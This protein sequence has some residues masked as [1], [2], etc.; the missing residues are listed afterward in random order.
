LLKLAEAHD[1]TI[2]EDDIFADFEIEPTTR[3]AAL[4]GLNRVIHIGSFSKTLSA[5]LRCGFIS[6]NASVIEPLLD[7]NLAIHLGGGPGSADIVHRVLTNGFY[8]RHTSALRTRLG[9]GMG[10]TI[11]KIHRAGLT[12]WIE[13]RGGIFLW[14]RLPD[15]LKA[16]D[17]AKFAL[18]DG[19]VLAPGDAFSLSKTA[20]P[21]LRFNVAQCS[22]PR[23][24][25]ILAKAMDKAANIPR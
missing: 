9:A 21:Y 5:S 13:P 2:I 12:P 10:T 17:V 7:L 6:A 18:A 20:S 15:G 3:L 23:V 25:P 24:F 1:L 22:D 4:D 19:M 11:R 16:A 8:R 14:A